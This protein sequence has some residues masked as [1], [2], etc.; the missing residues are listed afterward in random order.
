MNGKTALFDETV[1]KFILVGIVNTLVGAGIMFLLYNF[2]GCS[3]W[4]SS[5]ANY[6]VGGIVSYF[7]NKYF[8]FKNK[9]KNWQQVCKFVVNL[10][11]C[12]VLGYGIA[13]IVSDLLL[14]QIDQVI[15]ENVAMIV[16]MCLYTVLNYVGQRFW[17]FR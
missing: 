16:G 2:A 5:T 11:I 15:R 3:Y 4:I 1:P 13:K 7:L 12:Y 6:I 10:I 9:D 17:T 8:T 14:S